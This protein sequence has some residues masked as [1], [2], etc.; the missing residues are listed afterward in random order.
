M[1]FDAEKLVI[2][3]GCEFTYESEHATPAV[4]LVRPAATGKHR[5]RAE[6]WTSE[7]DLEARDYVD[8]YGNICRRLTIPPGAA[9][10][11]YD[12]YVDM[13][14]ALDPEDRAASQHGPD[15][16][17][18]ETLLYLLPSRYCHSDVLGEKA[19]Q[20]FGSIEPGW[21]RVQ[22]IVDFVHRHLEFG[23]GSSTA[24]TTA[25]DAFES[26]TGVCRDFAHL[27]ITFARA[28]NVPA[29]YVFGYLPDI[30]VVRP[31]SPMD[32]CAWFEAYLGDR[33]WTFDPRNKPAPKK[34]VR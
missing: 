12:A 5:L 10:I 31:D 18:D 2:S 4:F 20:L 22:A 14:A 34:D 9:R 11:R 28:M 33:W 32:F 1:E 29:R 6:R 25:V 27:A 19:W 26:R 17:P 7:P 21:D 3:V 8:L 15:D 16:L 30:D 13:P 24:N 23:Y